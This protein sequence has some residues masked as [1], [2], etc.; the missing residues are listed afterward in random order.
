MQQN[1]EIKSFLLKLL[2]KEDKILKITGKNPKKEMDEQFL[3]CN[4]I[5]CMFLNITFSFFD[6][7]ITNSRKRI[8]GT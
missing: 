1:F 3:I 5:F 6:L 8:E 7:F 4:K 2:C